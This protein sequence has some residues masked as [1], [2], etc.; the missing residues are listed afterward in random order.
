[1]YV[2]GIST[3]TGDCSCLL[4]ATC[5]VCATDGGLVICCMLS[6][7]RCCVDC[8]QQRG[9]G[10]TQTACLTAGFYAVA[11][12]LCFGQAGQTCRL[13]V[14]MPPL[15]LAVY[16]KAQ[17]LHLCN[18]VYKQFHPSVAT[19]AHTCMSTPS[20]VVPPPDTRNYHR[21]DRFSFFDE[22]MSMLQQ[23]ALCMYW[24]ME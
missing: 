18:F 14:T 23:P 15:L 13:H 1:M 10:H 12:G 9:Y 17:S 7:R 16:T 3:A 4:L 8:K 11:E 5:H 20:H 22:P 21:S 19:N 24:Q 2:Q 6:V